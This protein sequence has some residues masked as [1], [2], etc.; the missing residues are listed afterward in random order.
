MK[1]D[2]ILYGM[3]MELLYLIE[4]TV[5]KTLNSEKKIYQ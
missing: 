4:N 2:P 3:T 5:G 1:I